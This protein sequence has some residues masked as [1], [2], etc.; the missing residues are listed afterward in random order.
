MNGSL[1]KWPKG[2]FSAC[3]SHPDSRP[4]VGPPR[5]SAAEHTRT[6]E[7]IRTRRRKRDSVCPAGGYATH[8]VRRAARGQLVP[9]HAPRQE[10]SRPAQIIWS[11]P[12][13]VVRGRESATNSRERTGGHVV[14]GRLTTLYLNSRWPI[15]YGHFSLSPRIQ[16]IS[17]RSPPNSRANLPVCAGRLDVLGCEVS[18]GR[19]VWEAS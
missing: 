5:F 7:K 15:G 17:V 11:L 10:Y 6:Q 3:H 2:P 13:G 1:L 18:W 16:L 4:S 8:G 14:I 9:T 19:R 12:H